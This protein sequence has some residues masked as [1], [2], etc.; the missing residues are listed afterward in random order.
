MKTAS[1]SLA[2]LS[3]TAGALLLAGC[4]DPNGHAPLLFVSTNSFGVDIGASPAAGQAP[5]LN[6]G[7]KSV[8]LAVVP[9]TTEAKGGSPIRGCY[10]AARNAT[11]A[12]ACADGAPARQV[13]G[14]ATV[15]SSAGELSLVALRDDEQKLAQAVPLPRDTK[16]APVSASGPQPKGVPVSAPSGE[17]FGQSI[18]DSL[19]VYSSFSG[20]AKAGSETG[21]QLGKAFA[22]GVAA[23]QLTEGINYYLQYKG[24]TAATASDAAKETALRTECM[25]ALITAKEKS[26]PDSLLPA[27]NE[28]SVDELRFRTA[29]VQVLTSAVEKKVPQ[30]KL[31]KC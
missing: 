6:L 22:T 17:R 14:G 19:S 10:S 29:C 25:Q 9:V 1:L 28:K 24:Q 11:E 2:S 3:L 4:A 7:Y 8:D 31:P 26:V 21:V 27:C 20:E 16:A 18:R 12:G 13:A 15:T 23:Q 5:S 30:D